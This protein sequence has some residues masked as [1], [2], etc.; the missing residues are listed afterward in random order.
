MFSST[1]GTITH[2]AR[3][4]PTRPFQQRQGQ[5]LVDH[6]VRGQ[7]H[8]KRRVQRLRFHTPASNEHPHRARA[9]LIERN[10]NRP[11]VDRRQG[12]VA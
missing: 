9:Q 4:C 5:V 1:R 11:A 2:P 3:G 7:P 6:Q 10:A 8:V 12:N